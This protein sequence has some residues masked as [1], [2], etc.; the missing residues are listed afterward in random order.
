MTSTLRDDSVP[1]AAAVESDVDDTTPHDGYYYRVDSASALRRLSD[2]SEFLPKRWDC[3]A[4]PWPHK[5][6]IA[7]RGS[8]PDGH[9][10]FRL[11]FW[12]RKEPALQD[13]AMR[14]LH[15]PHI[16]VRIS[17]TAVQQALRG[18]NFEEDDFL[19]GEADLIWSVHASTGAQSETFSRVGVPLRDFDV[20]NAADC[21]WQPWHEASPLLPDSSRMGAMGWF[22]IAMR[23]RQGGP[24]LAY[25]KLLPTPRWRSGPTHWL[26]L[27]LDEFARGTLGSED[28]AITIAVRQ[29][30]DG[31]LGSLG[32]SELAVLTVHATRDR[33]WMEQ[34]AVE[35]EEGRADSWLAAWL[36]RLAGTSS[37]ALRA[38]PHAFED[39]PALYELV[40]R[41]GL[42]VIKKEFAAA[43]WSGRP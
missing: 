22:P 16:M 20:W 1:T 6:L 37:G 14:G 25:W 26:L 33:V 39:S 35:W 34:L 12:Q 29:L 13:L 40:R 19:P 23:T 9:G 18:W 28:G 30:A 17:R 43:T 42:P 3:T 36:R 32:P 8:L 15:E 10:I 21:S 11:S 38:R 5:S 31:P 41:S 24:V 7:A 4:R 27:T 2:A